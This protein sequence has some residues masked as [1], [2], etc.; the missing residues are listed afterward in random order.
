MKTAAGHRHRPQPVALA[1]DD[2]EHR[3]LQRRA[4]DEY[5]ADM[6]NLRR[7]LGLGTHHEAGRV[8][9]A[10]NGQAVTIAKLEKARRLVGCRGIDGA[11]QMHRIIGEQAH[12]PA[13]DPDERRDHAGAEI[14][15][16]LQHAAGVGERPDQ[17][18][19]VVDLLAVF[20]HR[21]A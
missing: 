20:G 11:A 6:P 16:Q 10:E 12:G 18:T 8:A 13:L 19:H 17:R 1:W 7:A 3:N 14:A 9:Q 21:A 2:A 5:A 4:D 15:A